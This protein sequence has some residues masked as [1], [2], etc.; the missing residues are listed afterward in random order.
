[1]YLNSLFSFTLMIYHL[2]FVFSSIEVFSRKPANNIYTNLY[3]QFYIAW[4]IF[5]YLINLFTQKM[6]DECKTP[7]TCIFTWSLRFL[8]E[9]VRSSTR[10]LNITSRSFWIWIMESR[11]RFYS[12]RLT[13]LPRLEHFFEIWTKYSPSFVF[14]H[15][16]SLCQQQTLVI[17]DFWR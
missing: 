4:Y 1:M 8:L 6:K 14:S 16:E 10:P 13:D 3:T 7:D 17:L 5:R 11:I 15:H 12:S 9:S 2:A